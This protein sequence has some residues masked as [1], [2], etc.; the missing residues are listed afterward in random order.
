MANRLKSILLYLV[1]ME[2]LS[3]VESRQILDGV[4]FVHEAIHSLKITK[5][6]GMLLK[7]DIS[8]SYDKLSWKFMRDMLRDY[9]F[10]QY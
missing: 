3:F 6:L 1:F 2:Q 4:I 5:K 7:L 8:K 9:G 10:N